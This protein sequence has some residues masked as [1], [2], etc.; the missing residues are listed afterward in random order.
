VVT[1]PKVATVRMLVTK[2]G[3]RYLARAE[4]LSILTEAGSLEE[5]KR[6]I[7]EAVTLHLD[8]GE[9]KR[10]GLPKQPKIEVV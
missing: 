5:L 6:N 3:P 4:G 7:R 1:K 10:Y 8:D 9:H 2:E